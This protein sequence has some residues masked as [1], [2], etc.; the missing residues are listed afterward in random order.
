MALSFSNCQFCSTVLAFEPIVV[1]G[2]TFT[3]APNVCEEC[4]EKKRLSL[5]AEVQR[6]LYEKFKKLCPPA[7]HDTDPDHPDMPCPQKLEKIV[8][9][10]FGPRGLIVH[11]VTRRGK[12][13]AVWLLIRRLILEGRTVQALTASEF[14]NQVAVLMGSDMSSWDDWM[15]ELESADVVFID[16]L[17]KA[18]MT[19]RGEAELFNLIDHRTSHL[20]PMLFTTNF[21]GSVLAGKISAD[22][23]EPIIER[24]RE[25]CQ[26]IHL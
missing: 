21:I 16:D 20:K 9:W 7:Y 8:G 1:F 4:K 22:R 17:G 23:S 14:S 2:H 18:K 12:T 15:Q 25:F 5:E 3:L 26:S 13:R 6:R 19:E 11:G 10:Q 24:I